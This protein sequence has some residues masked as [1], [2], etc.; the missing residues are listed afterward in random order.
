[1]IG[2]FYG[3]GIA[4]RQ[5]RNTLVGYILMVRVDVDA[6]Q[7]RTIHLQLNQQVL[8]GFFACIAYSNLSIDC[9]L[10]IVCIRHSRHL[11]VADMH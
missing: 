6:I 11:I 4:S 3:N 5:F 10:R 9:K 8:C 2:K 7:F 1:M